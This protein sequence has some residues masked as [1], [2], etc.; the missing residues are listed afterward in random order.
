MLLMN[1][2]GKQ[3][4][5][6]CFVFGLE[7]SREQKKRHG[8]RHLYY[9]GAWY[10]GVWMPC[11]NTRL[12]LHEVVCNVWYLRLVG[13]F[14]SEIRKHNHEQQNHTISDNDV[15]QIDSSPNFNSSPV[16]WMRRTATPKMWR[17][18]IHKGIKGQ[19]FI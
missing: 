4:Y 15:R 9:Y 5:E 11:Q 12:T 18:N 14:V 10:T 19:I 7:N 2:D 17:T 3:N 1:Q 16:S 13:S 8:R 6:N